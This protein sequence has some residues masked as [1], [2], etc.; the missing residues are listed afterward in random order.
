MLSNWLFDKA[1]SLV[2]S[3]PVLVT[4]VLTRP[5]GRHSY[6]A[7]TKLTSLKEW[8]KWLTNVAHHSHN[9]VVVSRRGNLQEAAL[10]DTP[11]C[12]SSNEIQKCR[13]N[14]ESLL[15][16]RHTNISEVEHPWPK[17]PT[18]KTTS[19][20][21][22]SK[23]RKSDATHS[24]KG[25]LVEDEP[26]SNG[27]LLEAKHCLLQELHTLHP[28]ASA[29]ATTDH[30]ADTNTATDEST[31]AA[32]KQVSALTDKCQ[33]HEQWAKVYVQKIKPILDAVQEKD[34]ESMDKALLLA[35]QFFNKWC[36]WAA[37]N[38]K[39]ASAGLQGIVSALRRQSN[40][41]PRLGGH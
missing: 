25:S 18:L 21:P 17:A 26:T 4:V 5:E 32:H 14:L 41:R 31:A 28:A 33:V 9:Q 19:E 23:G 11:F 39:S 8:I 10:H 1:D 24:L 37:D 38:A 36:R 15:E 13:D 30:T 35:G 12:Y 22:L 6:A 3:I 27:A 16:K 40:R 20:E 34:N 7:R 29:G 2:F